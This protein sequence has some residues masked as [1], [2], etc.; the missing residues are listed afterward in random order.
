MGAEYCRPLGNKW[1]MAR[2]KIDVGTTQLGVDFENNI[3][4]VLALGIGNMFHLAV[5]YRE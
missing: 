5:R 3:R 4:T 1:Y 2:R